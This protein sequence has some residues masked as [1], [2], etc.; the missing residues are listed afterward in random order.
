LAKFVPSVH[1]RRKC[2]NSNKLEPINTTE[3]SQ[4]KQGRPS[5]TQ[6]LYKYF[7]FVDICEAAKHNF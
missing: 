2:P 5:Q 3:E 4:R 6:Q 7:N 1:K